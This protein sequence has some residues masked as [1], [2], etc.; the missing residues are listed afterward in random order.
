MNNSSES[1]FTAGSHKEHKDFDDGANALWSLFA[2]QAKT[3]DEARFQSLVGD[4][5]GVLL[6]AGLFS[7]VL[8]SF[9]VQSIQK[10]RPD[11]AQQSAYYQNQSLAML[12]LISQQI[13]AN[14]SQVPGPSTPP[15]PYLAPKP[16]SSDI[17]VNI[18]WLTSL[19]CSL[20]AALLAILI[21]QWVRSYMQVFQ[22]YDHPLKRA[23]FRQFFF[24]GAKG[25][26][27]LAEA[28]PGLI[29]LSLF[30]F[31]IGLGDSMLDAN[32]TVG[33]TTIVS[34]TLC[35]CFYLYTV[36]APVWNPQSPYRN[37]YSRLILYLL[38]RFYYFLRT[39]HTPMSM[40]AD[41]EQVVMKETP[42]R[43]K[44]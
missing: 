20:S 14:G 38:R 44:T 9:L 34:I 29:H 28:V 23:R 36:L 1:L 16:S 39:R 13:A 42:E 35:G 18:C 21:Q 37:P 2:K 33:I 15:P 40:E 6:F 5:D 8:T 19:V 27:T 31:F 25:M 17:L 24:E 10:L 11:P 4:M 12:A 43:K 26:P 41:R 3:H 30:L 32:A 22:L 7:A